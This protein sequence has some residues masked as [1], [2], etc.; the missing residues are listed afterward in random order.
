MQTW[1]FQGNPK[2]YDIDGY[3]ASRPSRVVWLVTRYASEMLIGDRV[4]LWRNQ[5][6]EKGT[7]GIIAEAIVSELPRLRSEDPEGIAFW[8]E[9][10]ER[11]DS[12]QVR[13]ALRTV[14]VA[15]KKEVIRREWLLEDP[16]LK[17][18]PNLQMQA[19]TNYRIAPEH[20]ERLDALWSRTGRDWSRNESLAGLWAYAQSYGGPV[21]SLPNSPVAEV[22]V[23]IGRAVSGVYAK[24]MNFRALDPRATGEGMKAAGATDKLVW[25][26]FFDAV[27]QSLRPDQ[28]NDEFNR[29][30]ASKQS[31]LDA[32]IVAE[33]VGKEAQ[34]LEN[35][36]LRQLLERYARRETDKMRPAVRS[37]STRM[38][39]RDPLVVAIGRKRA[40]H[41]CEVRDCE[42]LSFETPNGFAY[43]EIHHIDPLADGGEDTIENVACLC[44]LHHREVHLGKRAK[45]L[46]AQL[47][48]LRWRGHRAGM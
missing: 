31:P 17:A 44:P 11:S 28:L 23:R 45:E 29:I 37:L 18:L 3:L 20:V 2:E 38:Y 33:A 27:T 26:E 12:P 40:N 19:A 14:R 43:V 41:R 25:A 39:E 16:I 7:A 4:Y 22:A 48:A 8:R 32:K 35:Y 30:W 21:S 6:Q 42:H 36:D 46:T 34:H 15:S 13:V 24:V 1:I 9:S 10:S 5:G 47:K